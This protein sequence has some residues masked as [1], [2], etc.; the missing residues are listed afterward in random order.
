MDIGHASKTYPTGYGVNFMQAALHIRLLL[1]CRDEGCQGSTSRRGVR[2][3][4]TQSTRHF[5][6]ITEIRRTIGFCNQLPVHPRH[7]YGGDMV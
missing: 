3:C 6:N 2:P 5:S 7:P 1:M 4:A